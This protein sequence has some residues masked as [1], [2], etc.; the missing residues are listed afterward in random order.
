MTI[1]EKIADYIKLK[2]LNRTSFAQSLNMSNALLSNILRGKSNFTI[3]QLMKIK[4]IYFD[5]DFNLLFEEGEK[6]LKTGH[7]DIGAP[8]HIKKDYD[9]Y[10]KSMIEI[11][12][13]LEKIVKKISSLENKSQI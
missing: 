10:Q 1:N 9:N 13:D 7:F 2:K 3:T 11:Q 12:N 8:T 4:T 6:Y 5:I